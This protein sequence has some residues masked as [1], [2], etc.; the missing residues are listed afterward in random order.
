MILYRKPQKKSIGGIFDSILGGIGKAGKA[1]GNFADKITEADKD[2][3]PL[4]T[5]GIQGLGTTIANATGGDAD[6]PGSYDLSQNLT[7]TSGTDSFGEQ[8]LP[9]LSDVN[10]GTPP[11][12][13]LNKKK[14]NQKPQTTNPW[15]PNY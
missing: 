4:V 3:N 12:D 2:A 5:A 1:V 13:D 8:R 11:I 6:A 10:L 14:K 15:L 9:D 7:S